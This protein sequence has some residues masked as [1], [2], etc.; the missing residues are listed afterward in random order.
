MTARPPTYR[1]GAFTLIEIMVVCAIIG[2]VMTIA[3]PS[4]H[5]QLHPE[6]MQKA[7]NDMLEACRD[8]RAHAVLTDTTAELVIRPQARQIEVVETRTA[9]PQADP[10]ASPSVS[11]EEWRMPEPESASS[12]PAIATYRLSNRI[13]IEAIGLNGWDWTEDEVVRVRFYKDGTADQFNIVLGS[14]RGE[15]RMVFTD[16]VTGLA[17]V[18]TEQQLQKYAR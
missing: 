4:I 9:A 3:I 16:V 17:D 13:F 11:G 6:S 7:V 14:D 1:S 8:A 12:G 2:I 15:Q 18:E 10:V 5:R